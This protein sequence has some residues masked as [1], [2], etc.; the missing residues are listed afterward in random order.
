MTTVVNR[1]KEQHD[2]YIGRP[3]IFGNP[4]RVSRD[5]PRAEA[6][7]K[8]R[9]WFLKRI[10]RDK[11]FRAYVEA[12]RGKRLG[13]YCAPLACHGDVIVEWLNGAVD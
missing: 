12:L 3:S 7:T 5:C 6:I 9:V 13:C 10:E 4:Y 1:A 8:Y 11:K 2:V